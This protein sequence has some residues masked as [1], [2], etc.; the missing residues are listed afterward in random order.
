[1]N[2]VRRK[3]VRDRE[4]W[5]TCV[6]ELLL[7][8]LAFLSLLEVFVFF[9][10]LYQLIFLYK[11]RNAKYGVFL[12]SQWLAWI[13]TV[14]FCVYTFFFSRIWNLCTTEFSSQM[15]AMCWK[16]RFTVFTSV[17][18]SR[19]KWCIGAVHNLAVYSS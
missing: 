15:V 16:Y 7:R 10:I 3:D 17:A 8:C 6:K 18:C 9:L 13:K 1:M 4:R 12:W 2:S 5:T 14:S 11:E 19:L